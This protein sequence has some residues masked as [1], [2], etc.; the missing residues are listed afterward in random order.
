MPVIEFNKKDLKRLLGRNI[1]DAELEEELFKMGVELDGE[2]AEI[3]ADR[4]D[5][6][7]P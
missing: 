5:M 2:K 1:S 7:T 3:N 4:P 6:S